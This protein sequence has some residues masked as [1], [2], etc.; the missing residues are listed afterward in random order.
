MRPPAGHFRAV[1]RG[2]LRERPFPSR[3]SW[4]AGQPTPPAPHRPFAA[5]QRYG[6][7]DP[8]SHRAG[9]H[10]YG[11]VSQRLGRRSAAEVRY[12]PLPRTHLMFKGTGTSARFPATRRR[13]PRRPG[14]TPSPADYTAYFQRVQKSIFATMMQYEADRMTNL[15][16]RRGG[17]TGAR[18]G[19]GG[20]PDAHRQRSG[21]RNSA[22]AVRLALFNHHPYGTPVIGWM[23]EIET[24]NREDALAYY[25]RFYTPEKR[26]SSS[27]ATSKPRRSNGSPATSTAKTPG[28]A[29]SCRARRSR[30]ARHRLVTPRRRQGR[31]GTIERALSRSLHVRTGA[32]RIRALGRRRRI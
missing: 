26:H 7:E 19:S 29:R 24:L 11:L 4:S 32:G 28:A 18:R 22:K 30:R 5:R 16:C 3:T 14:K 27:P 31:A 21:R 23:H 2:V 17:R 10:P 1:A 25:E 15:S 8:D 12:R 9:R 20:A 13:R 6:M